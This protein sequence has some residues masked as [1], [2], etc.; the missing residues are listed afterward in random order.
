MSQAISGTPKAKPATNAAPKN[1][2]NARPAGS[3]RRKRNDHIHGDDWLN[4]AV[5]SKFGVGKTFLMGTSTD[6]D[7]MNEVLYINVDFGSKG[8]PSNF[9]GDI[10]DV[11]N[12]KEYADVYEFAK[13]YA[14]ARDSDNVLKMRQLEAR[15]FEEPLEAIEE[16]KRYKTIIID[17]LSDIQRLNKY[18]L[19]GIDTKT[20]KLD[21]IPDYIRS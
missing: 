8:L 19:I 3:R 21:E 15:L 17:D 10:Y 20:T 16:P 13:A 14:V 9:T 5:Y 2:A 12:Y 4:G 11:T 18:M 7:A 1:V 6:V